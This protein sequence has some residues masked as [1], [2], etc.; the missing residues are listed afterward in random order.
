M[1]QYV[2]VDPE[3]YGVGMAIGCL[4]RYWR[5]FFAGLV[6]IGVIG[7]L[8]AVVAGI[9]E[10]SHRSSVNQIASRIETAS[11]VGRYDPQSKS[12]VVD[13]Q[14]VNHG[15]EP[16]KVNIGVQLPV[17]WNN[18]NDGND[19]TWTY[20][21]STVEGVPAK[22]SITLNPNRAE[23]GTI[24]MDEWHGS[25]VAYYVLHCKYEI[26]QPQLQILDVQ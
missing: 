5:L 16:V 1:P 4:I 20:G 6:I 15:N 18:C 19:H 14:L 2:P 24:R 22:A 9:G 13:Y 8:G 7:L 21:G 10:M 23:Q 25:S 12:F 17:R 26:R 11:L 3:A